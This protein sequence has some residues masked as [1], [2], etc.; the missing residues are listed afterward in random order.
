M[1]SKPTQRSLKYCRDMGW[2]VQVVEYWL[3]P[4][5][6]RRDLFC[7]I[8]I[9]A[10]DGQPGVIGIQA[11][12]GGDLTKRLKKALEQHHLRD[13][14]QAGNR[15]EVW[16]WRPVAAY[17]KDGVRKVHDEWRCRCHQVTLDEVKTAALCR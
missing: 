17:R 6:K 7:C 14:L 9:V 13:W 16:G 4:A 1:A 15:F 12:T 2:P 11:C 3:A 5:R 10:L 8:D